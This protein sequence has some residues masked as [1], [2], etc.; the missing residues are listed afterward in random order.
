MELENMEPRATGLMASLRKRWSFM[1]VAA[2]LSVLASSFLTMAVP[3]PAQ[4][5]G[6]EQNAGAV[7]RIDKTVLTSSK[8]SQEGI[9]FN[10]GVK[11]ISVTDPETEYLYW[12]IKVACDNFACLETAIDDLLPEELNG[13]GAQIQSVKLPT[14]ASHSLTL[15]KD[16]DG[17]HQLG[18][19]IANMQAGAGADIVIKMTVPSEAKDPDWVHAAKDIKNTATSA[20]KNT[21]STASSDA[22]VDYT[23][24]R[25]LSVGLDETW[26]M[27]DGVG[28][29][30]LTGKNTSN[31]G[32][33]SWTLN[34]PIGGTNPFDYVDLDG[35]EISTWPKGA[36]SATITFAPEGA[37]SVTVAAGSS[38]DLST[39]NLEDV[40][41]FSV[42]FQ[43][44]DGGLIERDA[45]FVVEP[46]VTQR[47]AMRSNP[48]TKLDNVAEKIAVNNKAETFLERG[49]KKSNVA[50]DD[51][52]YEIVPIDLKISSKKVFAED[53]VPAGAGG[54][55]TIE[56]T[57]KSPVSLDSMTLVDTGFFGE[58]IT[59]DGISVS[60]IPEGVTALK[61]VVTK[62]GVDTTFNLPVVDGSAKLSEADK[63]TVTAL[64]T[65]GAS[66]KVV[67]EGKIA[68]SAS[69]NAQVTY[70]TDP[71]TVLDAKNTGENALCSVEAA[72][73]SC[74][75]DNVLNA[76]GKYKD[77]PVE[78][79]ETKDSVTIHEPSIEASLDK[80]FSD[81]K[82]AENN[83]IFASLQ[84]NVKAGGKNVAPNKVVIAD[85]LIESDANNIWKHADL[86]SVSGLEHALGEDTEVSVVFHT[87]SGPQTVKVPAGESSLAVPADLVG[88]VTKVEIV[89]DAE[90]SFS[91]GVQV[92]PTLVFDPKPRPATGGEPIN[93]LPFDLKQKITNTA[94]VTGEAPRPGVTC[95]TQPDTCILTGVDSDPA[96]A[97]L[98]Y[99]KEPVTGP[100]PGPDIDISK[101]WYTVANGTAQPF[102]TQQGTERRTKTPWRINSQLTD[103]VVIQEPSTDP[104]AGVGANT[105][106]D[107]TN[108]TSISMDGTFE[109]DRV[110][111]VEVY[112]SGQGWKALGTN[113]QLSAGGDVN[114]MNG[115]AMRKVTLSAELQA[116]VT[117]VR[118]TVVEDAAVR[119]ASKSPLAPKA[120]SGIVVPNPGKVNSTFNFDWKLRDS[121]RTNPSDWI[122]AKDENVLNE[123]RGSAW[124]GDKTDTEVAP[125]K[126]PISDPTP[127]VN[128][129]KQIVVNNQV[130][131]SPY[132]VA[133]PE[134]SDFTGQYPSYTYRLAVNNESSSPANSLRI[135]D[136][137]D[138]E[139][140]VVP[141][142]GDPRVQV[143][144]VFTS[145]GN[146]KDY[147][148]DCAKTSPFEAFG[149]T[150]IT[151]S[152][153]NVL[154]QEL[155]TL[156]LWKYDAASK[157]SSVE[158]ISLR[159]FN[160]LGDVAKKEKLAQ[161]V[162]F[163][164]LYVGASGLEGA[165]SLWKKDQIT[166]DVSVELRKTYRSTDQ[167]IAG[168]GEQ[169]AQFKEMTN[170]VA[171]Q[172]YHHVLANEKWDE[173]KPLDKQWGYV[174]DAES[175]GTKL[176]DGTLDIKTDKVIDAPDTVQ[177]IETVLEPKRGMASSVTISA[178]QGASTIWP[179]RVELKDTTK[180]FWNTFALASNTFKV[181]S[182][183]GA[184][185]VVVSVLTG[186]EQTAKVAVTQAI[187]GQ[188]FEVVLPDDIALESI[189]GFV[190]EYFREI[191]GKN[192]VFDEKTLTPVWST[193]AKF[194]IVPRETSVG[195]VGE[196]ETVTFP[197]G[198][199]VKYTN[200]VDSTVE[201]K[202][203]GRLNGEKTATDPADIA[204]HSGTTKI[205]VDKAADPASGL[206][207]DDAVM[208]TLKVTNKGTGYIDLDTL[209]DYLPR[210]IAWSG[211]DP[212]VSFNPADGVDAPESWSY[213]DAKRQLNFV[214]A[215]GEGRMEPGESMTI[216]IPTTVRAGGGSAEEL[217]NR[218]VVRTDQPHALE[219]CTH[220]TNANN[221][222]TT[223]PE[224]GEKLPGTDCG[225]KF[226][227]SMTTD[228]DIATEKWVNGNLDSKFD[229]EG[230][231]SNSANATCAPD[232]EGFYTR[233]CADA[234][235]IGGKD[236]WKIPVTNT[237]GKDMK[238]FVLIDEL[239]MPGDKLISGGLPR[240]STFSTQFQLAE[241]GVALKPFEFVRRAADGSVDKAPYSVKVEVSTQQ[242]ACTESNWFNDT[243]CSKATWYEFDA[244][245]KPVGAAAQAA[246]PSRAALN[247]IKSFRI[248]FEFA[249]GSYFQPGQA[250]E[251]K[252]FTTT[253][254]KSFTDGTS[255]DELR[256][257]NQEAWNQAAVSATPVSGN[258]VNRVASIVGLHIP[259]GSLTVEKKVDG[260]AQDFAAQSFT[261]TATCTVAGTKLDPISVTLNE[262]NG[263]SVT[264]DKLPIG[265]SCEIEET[266]TYLESDSEI[267]V[268]GVVSEGPATILIDSVATKTVRADQLA[269]ITNTYDYGNLTVSKAI[270]ANDTVGAAYGPFDFTLTC[271]PFNGKVIAPINFTL[272]D[273]GNGTLS[274]T[275]PKNT[276]PANADCVLTETKT[277]N[278]KI[279]SFKVDGNAVTAKD[280]GVAVKIGT[281]TTVDVTNEF[282]HGTLSVTKRATGAGADDFGGENFTVTAVCT[283]NGTE[284]YSGEVT[285]KA[286]ETATFK[287]RGKD[288]KLP[289]GADCVI[290][291]TKT[292]G[293]NDSI[294]NKGTANVGIVAGENATTAS[295]NV[296]D[297]ENIFTVGNIDLK[298]VV[299]GTGAKRYGVDSYTIQ[300]VCQYK[301]DGEDKKVLWDNTTGTVAKTGDDFLNVDLNTS[302]EFS[303][304]V[305]GI[306]AGADCWIAGESVSGGAQDRAFSATEKSPVTIIANGKD[307]DNTEVAAASITNVFKT[308]SIAIQKKEVGAGVDRFGGNDYVVDLSCTYMADGKVEDILW[309]GSKTLPPTLKEA[310]GYRAVVDDLM[311]GAECW[312]VSETQTGGANEIEFS[313][314][315]ENPVKVTETAEPAAE[316]TATVTNTFNT[317]DLTINKAILGDGAAQYG[318]NEF[319]VRLACTYDVDGAARPITWGEDEFLDIVLNQA[320][321]YT[322]TETGLIEGAECE[323]TQ[324][325]RKGGANE[326]DLGKPAK[327]VV[328]GVEN[329]AQITVTNTFN[330]GSIQVHKNVVGE[331]AVRFGEQTY[332]ANVSCVYDVNGTD[333]PVFANDGNTTEVT[334]NKDN[335]YAT[336]IDNLPVGADCWV[337]EETQQGGANDVHLGEHVI[338]PAAAAEGVEAPALP[339][340][341]LT[342]TFNTA[343]VT[344][345]KDIVGA[346][347]KQY[348][349]GPFTV[350]LA[351]TYEKDGVDTDILWDGEPTLDV[352]LSKENGYSATIIDLI[353]D[354]TCEIT[355][356]SVD[357]GA[358]SKTWTAPVQLIT[359][360]SSGSSDESAT[361]DVASGE[362]TVTNTFK[363]G[364][365]GVTKSLSGDG[366][367]RFGADQEFKVAAS[368]TYQDDNVYTGELTIMGGETQ[369]FLDTEGNKVELPVGS[370][371]ALEETLSGGASESTFENNGSIFIADTEDIDV[372]SENIANLDNLFNVSQIEV[373]KD[374]V[375]S[376]AA[377]AA[378]KTYTVELACTYLKDEVTTPVL[379]DGAEKLSL[380]LSPEN[381]YSQ[382]VPNL[383]S[384]AD[385]VVTDETVT[386]GATS[387]DTGDNV[388]VG[389][390]GTDPAVITVTNTFEIGEVEVKK[391]LKGA[392]AHQAKDL[393]FELEVQCLADVDGVDT[394]VL[395]GGNDTYTAVANADNKFK[396]VVPNVPLGAECAVVNEVDAHGATKT[397][398]GKSVKV[399]KER[400]AKITVVN[401]FGV[402]IV[403]GNTEEGGK[404][405]TTGV[406][407][408]GSGLAAIALIAGGAYLLVARRR[409]GRHA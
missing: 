193:E 46:Q 216:K 200:H 332:K 266:G 168:T 118:I 331:A 177:G 25:K 81:S 84:A 323:I 198:T 196:P 116:S 347:A 134:L 125:S 398:L 405:P 126:N 401:T 407:I 290:A 278:A 340:I 112:I 393:S 317:G 37:G 53:H 283:Y 54:T 131:P 356:E 16:K 284:V 408:L 1:A 214:W 144:D 223:D 66:F 374:V 64:L 182:P 406:A 364:T 88:K 296:V 194:T 288:A 190:F 207:A 333:T 158:K 330:T 239:P 148:K 36:G 261:A 285:L 70:K 233:G 324:E 298:K 395:W 176:V 248:T 209:T 365:L 305:Y 11:D 157:V 183:K 376:G 15:G 130:Q 388:V 309:D 276:I 137:G 245:G 133:V 274:W 195:L 375:G 201:R 279:V 303:K 159:A 378:G 140:C 341:E 404:L 67:A 110:K 41:G 282:T 351:C 124:S 100:G 400:S 252:L 149:I 392:F 328:N 104:A 237:G 55:F 23:F 57:N 160:S 291:E 272:S 211:A 241:S 265:A 4:A 99:Y 145:G 240:N 380:D 103:A 220:D 217:T 175:V 205:S 186:K 147:F 178:H 213:D 231:K 242:H 301:V 244:D 77:R 9:D 69:L 6:G 146:V 3:A 271:A 273:T 337:T 344:I 91:Q 31:S 188:E 156:E 44:A 82:Y 275:A 17:R 113:G 114:W 22:T 38:P 108:L 318:Q 409:T 106:F 32:A 353:E 40:T 385:C 26:S 197:S 33:E 358:T 286:G 210:Q 86:V 302:N 343:Q 132:T 256:D 345:N 259:V 85:G 203:L 155:T 73:T 381:G 219:S 45:T 129:S 191:D 8:N 322:H 306:I 270:T 308:G 128:T 93:E 49:D 225:A 334:L 379:W 208:W 61:F 250:L 83:Y 42:E 387:V 311:V 111:S 204:L 139:S 260:A 20:I 161:V 75:A 297:V 294:V 163:S 179:N 215:Q 268:D 235:I 50:V 189:T 312:I 269:T 377:L 382:M 143:R 59:F 65:A 117:G 76:S 289:A 2:T 251:T 105:V 122:T 254:V 249:G 238:K 101:N 184:N 169:G 397:D 361:S 164:V 187:S 319:T 43:A 262:A 360:D 13:F 247:S 236:A 51:A 21:N 52:G 172:S 354:A 224:T 80:K 60:T 14:G 313:A 39:V 320:N 68:P 107:M 174:S 48:D 92:E 310:E 389:E 206:R 263:Y 109:W 151:I 5:A 368:C 230:A 257:P 89:Y 277:G 342:N 399:E 63:A 47:S 386:G 352:V 72:E 339:A 218:F 229:I 293:A 394:P 10:S 321:K 267:S 90:K 62:G 170:T 12:V 292:G 335:G 167:Q 7:T 373:R 94:T 115:R 180:E 142:L 28:S 185:K 371:C 336:Q 280:N 348:G 56:G 18:G 222:Q 383:I 295:D 402:A 329:Q 166:A 123:V 258:P 173:T 136:A 58:G 350:Q 384:G 300:L 30:S 369:Y 287:F 325:S 150:G 307:G 24:E 338:V 316:Q 153:L 138:H 212:T 96:A 27:V 162:G 120:G 243:S 370:E 34:D 327:I 299:E 359:D 221:L 181:K 390:P 98:Y 396:P 74:V 326:T 141:T 102:Y 281:D 366:A 391:E 202:G 226:K 171:A 403:D 95:E 119:S 363:V 304:R 127:G 79:P 255:A 135:T 234:T 349:A 97:E 199:P 362:I 357:G 71:T 154:D 29:M 367:D 192:L 232:S 314:T 19:S 372:A 346:G 78:A 227:V 121:K 246:F 228:A 355:G 253:S 152:P 165:G 87:A 35:L 315:K 264:I